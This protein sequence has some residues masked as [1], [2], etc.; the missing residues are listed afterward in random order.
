MTL[1][2]DEHTL[3][4]ALVDELQS[5]VDVGDIL[6]KF[7]ILDEGTPTGDYFTKV[8]NSRI[9]DI[10]NSPEYQKRILFTISYNIEDIIKVQL[11][12]NKDIAIMIQKVVLDKLKLNKDN[13]K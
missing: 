3:T 6:G 13:S 8:I 12:E 11:S 1:T 9:N 5:Q 4:Q 7:N 2:M 10:V